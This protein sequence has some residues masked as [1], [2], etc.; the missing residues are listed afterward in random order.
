[1]YYVLYTYFWPAL[2]V[3][4]TVMS[5]HFFILEEKSAEQSFRLSLAIFL[6]MIMWVLWSCLHQKCIPRY[7]YQLKVDSEAQFVH[8]LS[9]HVLIIALPWW[10]DVIHFFILFCLSDLTVPYE[11]RI[12]TLQRITCLCS[13]PVQFILQCSSWLHSKRPKKCSLLLNIMMYLRLCQRVI[14]LFDSTDSHFS[15][16]ANFLTYIHIDS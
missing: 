16:F 15:F 2:Y 11:S 13:R 10:L 14:D 12:S 8:I 9:T 5:S 7:C 1:M 6:S 4:S 3:A